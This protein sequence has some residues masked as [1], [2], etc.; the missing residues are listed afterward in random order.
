MLEVCLRYGTA[1]FSLALET[2]KAIKWQK[3]MKELIYL[4]EENGELLEL[5]NSK[6]VSIDERKDIVDN[7]LLFE[8]E[9][10]SSF[11]KLIL[12]NGRISYLKDILYSFNTLCN[13]HR[14]I[15]EGYVYSVEQLS[16]SQI[17]SI[18]NALSKKEG[19][20]IELRNLIDKSLIGGLKVVI[21]DRVYDDS[22]K[23]HLEKMKTT[24]IK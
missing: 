2:D 21:E 1:L 6:F 12:D 19:K 13:R 14:G 8:D 22:I 4:I 7:V 10:L 9:E 3:E 18:E 5:L 11:I 20:I 24:L 23:F 15:L 16:K 17:E